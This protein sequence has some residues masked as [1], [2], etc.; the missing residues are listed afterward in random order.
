MDFTTYL[1]FLLLLYVAHE[2]CLI[3]AGFYEQREDKLEDTT[4]QGKEET[5]HDNKSD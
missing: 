3:A 1:I 4:T 5:G 2:I